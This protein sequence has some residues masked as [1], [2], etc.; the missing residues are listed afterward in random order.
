MV[1][2]KMNNRNDPKQ[3][4]S[5]FKVGDLVNF[6]LDSEKKTFR[7]EDGEDRGESGEFLNGIVQRKLQDFIEVAAVMPDGNLKHFKVP[8]YSNEKYDHR[9]WWKPGFIMKWD[10]Q[11]LDIACECGYG[12]ESN[13]HFMFCPRHPKGNNIP[14][15]EELKEKLMEIKWVTEYSLEEAKMK[16]EME[17]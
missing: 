14:T 9:Q 10:T 15:K 8:N 3:R 11:H 6:E 12:N 16:L 13:L 1:P 17:I 5:F 2:T 4:R 7:Y